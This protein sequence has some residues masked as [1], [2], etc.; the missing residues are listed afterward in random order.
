MRFLFIFVFALFLFPTSAFADAEQTIPN[1]IRRIGAGDVTDPVDVDVAV[2]DTG[3]DAFN[4]DLNVVGGVDCSPKP[5][6]M[7]PGS[8]NHSL[9]TVQGAP[10]DP[11]FAINPLMFGPAW[12]DQNGH[13]THVSGIIAAKD[14]SFGVVGVA[15]GAR[16]WSVRVLDAQGFGTDDT[17]ACG[18]AWVVQHADVI[19]V[20]NISLGAQVDFDVREVFSACDATITTTLEDKWFPSPRVGLGPELYSPI[21]QHL[22]TL[23][24]IGIPVIVAAGN[25]DNEA[26][27]MYPAGFDEVI[28][29]S[30]YADFDGLPGG[31]AG[32][33][34]ACPML[35]G[36]DDKLYSHSN[37]TP[38][39]D[40]TSTHGEG[41]DISAP[42]TCVLSTVPGGYAPY[43]GT[44][45]AAPHVTGVVALIRA[46]YPTA[47][48]TRVYELLFSMAEPQ[49]ELF[50]DTDGQQEPLV[51]WDKD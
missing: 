10:A 44:S 51:Y 45:M 41:V 8:G 27:N 35:G 50:N 31:L 18:L 42:G 34:S 9:I 37:N 12:S 13:G 40:L 1:G 17:V 47:P 39:H 26:I 6:Y 11:Q 21:K 36:W 33:T 20:V 19:D 7:L 32:I 43:T 49:P 22:C 24:E 38:Y 15:P 29:V 16:L 46:R 3:I 28:S 48:L 14:N 5:R 30:N 4:P 2:I 23:Q 25:E